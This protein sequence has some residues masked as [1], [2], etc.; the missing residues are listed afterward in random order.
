LSKIQNKSYLINT[1]FEKKN[2]ID[3]RL[4]LSQINLGFIFFQLELFYFLKFGQ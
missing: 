2:L 1:T 4:V 3:F